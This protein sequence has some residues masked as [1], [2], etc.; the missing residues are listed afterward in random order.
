M[1]IKVV[2]NIKPKI[3]CGFIIP[4][5]IYDLYF[6]VT[7][8]ARAEEIIKMNYNIDPRRLITIV[9]P[10]SGNE[11]VTILVLY[12]TLMENGNRLKYLEYTDVDK[13]NFRIYEYDKKLMENMEELIE[14]I[15][16]GI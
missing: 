5:V 10:Y 7:D 2:K 14:T 11:P 12:D 3:I 4:N 16:G 1:G 6:A 13:F 8:R 9:Q 15:K